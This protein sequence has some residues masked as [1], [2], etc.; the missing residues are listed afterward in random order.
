V[1]LLLNQNKIIFSSPIE[2]YITE[3]PKPSH[4]FIPDAYKKMPNFS[5]KNML[6]RTVKMCMPFLD[7]YKMGYIIPFPVEL[8]CG[9]NQETGEVFFHMSESLPSEFMSF[10]KPSA[11]GE[12]QVSKELLYN[13]RSCNTVFKFTNPWKIKTPKGYSCL[14]TQPFNQNLDFKIIEGVVDTD[15]FKTRINFPFYTTKP[16]D[17]P[18]IIKKGSPMVQVIP[19]KRESWKIECKIDEEDEKKDRMDFFSGLYNNYKKLVWKKKSFD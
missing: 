8:V 18:F 2:K 13:L 3:K 17:K 9:Y 14:F 10:F 16:F 12:S 1:F 7:A 4:Y 11:H 5:D 6:D 19:F 15:E